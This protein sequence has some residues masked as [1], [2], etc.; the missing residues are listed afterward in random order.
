MT[1]TV[2][3][4]RMNPLAAMRNSITRA[5]QTAGESAVPADIPRESGKR[6][7]LLAAIL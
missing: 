4:A 6:A 1:F 5:K 7:S 3:S 2:S